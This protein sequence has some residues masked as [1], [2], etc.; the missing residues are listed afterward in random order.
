[1]NSKATVKQHQIGSKKFEKDLKKRLTR[2]KSFGII[3]KL[4]H[5]TAKRR[6]REAEKKRTEATR[7]RSEK[8]K[9]SC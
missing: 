3:D 5:G 1:M 8:S 9:K 2:K 7:K 6:Q 4:S